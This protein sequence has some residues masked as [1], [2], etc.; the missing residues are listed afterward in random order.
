MQ[1]NAFLAQVVER[2][3][4][5]LLVFGSNPKEGTIK[6]FMSR[7][8][9]TSEYKLSSIEQR[10]KILYSPE[11]NVRPKVDMSFIDADLLIDIDTNVGLVTI[12]LRV[13]LDINQT[14]MPANLRQV[15]GVFMYYGKLPSGKKSIY[16]SM[17]QFEA[18]EQ[19]KH[20]KE[21]VSGAIIA[22]NE[23][24]FADKVQRIRSELPESA[25]NAIKENLQ[26][27]CDTKQAE[28]LHIW[29]TNNNFTNIP[30]PEIL[31]MM[32]ELGVIFI[33]TEKNAFGHTIGKHI[34]ID[35]RAKK[36]IT[37]TCHSS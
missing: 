18:C 6:D 32:R 37:S 7:I 1:I 17:S 11:Y 34:S 15:N 24:A 20:L 13:K 8:T 3:I 25:I 14:L 30:R 29:F 12:N 36:F 22:A 31:A 33:K 35:W 9:D 5:N 19:V 28:L 2:Q 26:D 16:F 10:K 4:L 21:K 27:L 23:Q